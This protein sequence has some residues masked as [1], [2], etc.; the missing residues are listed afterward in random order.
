MEQVKIGWGRREISIDAPVQV[1]GQMYLRISEGIHDPL[2]ATALCVDGGEGEDVVLFCACDLLGYREDTAVLSLVRKKVTELC[3]EIPTDNI[4]FNATHSHNSPALNDT[5]EK[6]FDGQ[7]IYPGAKYREWFVEQCADAI[8]EA[9]NSRKEGGITYGYGNAVVAHSRRVVYHEDMSKVSRGN[10]TGRPN[11]SGTPSG[12]AVMYGETDHPL[13]SHFEAGADHFLNAMFTFD[14]DGKLTG[15]LANVPCPSQLGEMYSFLSADYWADVRERIARE[16]GPEVYLLNQCGAA[17]DLSPRNLLYKKAQGRRLRLKYDLDFNTNEAV[18]KTDT[19]YQKI[20]C[21][22]KDAADQIIAALKDVYSWAKKEIET[23][24]PV[25][26]ERKV[27]DLLVRQITDEE[28]AWC[29]ENIRYT[30]ANMPKPEDYEDPEAF[31]TAYSGAESKLRRNRN[32]LKWYEERK[33]NPTMPV[34][35][36]VARI[37]EVGF[38]TTRF[39]L[40][41]DYMHRVQARSPFTQTFIIQLAGAEGGRYLSTKRGTENKGYSA[42]IFCNVVGY[43]GGDQWVEETLGVL[44]KLAED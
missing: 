8:C 39:E 5:P 6:T 30:E 12:H 16:F 34:P 32:V 38:C 28:K 15:I 19:W 10:L 1:P 13:F 23:H 29:E 7:E 14:A 27:M 40:Y 43:E 22:R 24:V 9:W 42:S 18:R 36:N 41:M 17:G 44:N 2:Y 3:P 20:M 33:E 11:L 26:H 21:E 37:G 35:A 4:I 31:R 25:R